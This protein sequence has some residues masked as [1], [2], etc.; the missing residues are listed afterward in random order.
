M[1]MRRKIITLKIKV[2]W[3]VCK[4]EYLCT[5]PRGSGDLN[6]I[7]C[8]NTMHAADNFRVSLSQY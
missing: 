1:Q 4:K 5:S 6:Y 2:V 8:E 3:F 7:E